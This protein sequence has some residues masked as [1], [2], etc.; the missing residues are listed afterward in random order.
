MK[1]ITFILICLFSQLA[2]GAEVLIDCLGIVKVCSVQENK[3]KC[4]APVNESVVLSLNGE[5]LTSETPFVHF[6]EPCVISGDALTCSARSNSKD[7]GGALTENGSRQ[8]VLNTANGELKWRYLGVM[9][10][11]NIMYKKGYRGWSNTYDAICVPRVQ[12]GLP[13]P[14]NKPKG[15]VI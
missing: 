14:Q 7:L 12:E 8:L 4:D 1:K 9:T 3:T 15:K 11:A 10:P 2:F 6:A 13:K 5:R